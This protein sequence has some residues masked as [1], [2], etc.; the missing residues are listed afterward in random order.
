MEKE[1]GG[2]RVELSH[3]F[4]WFR[5]DFVPKTGTGKGNPKTGN[6]NPETEKKDPVLRWIAENVSESENV[7]MIRRGFDEGKVIEITYA[8]YDWTSNAH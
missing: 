7:E 5:G 6:G 8:P 2:L 1:D 4:K 3:L